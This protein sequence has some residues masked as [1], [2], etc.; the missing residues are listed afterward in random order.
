MEASAEAAS[1][2]DVGSEAGAGR[3]RDA[4][5]TAEDCRDVGG[6]GEVEDAEGDGHD[7]GDEDYGGEGSAEGVFGIKEATEVIK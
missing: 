7:G 6:G 3:G 5:A 4:A 1:A 2:A